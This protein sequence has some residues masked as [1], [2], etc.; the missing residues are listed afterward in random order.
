M[1]DK[2]L[3]V[4][5][6]WVG[7]LQEHH[8]GFCRIMT[9]SRTSV[10]KTQSTV[11][12]SKSIHVQGFLFLRFMDD[13]EV[14]KKSPVD[15]HSHCCVTCRSLS[16]MLPRDAPLPLLTVGPKSL[17]WSGASEK[18][19]KTWLQMGL[20]DASVWGH[21]KDGSP[22]KRNPISAAENELVQLCN[23][24]WLFNWD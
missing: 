21:Y 7:Q 18:R 17:D 15:I 5:L 12:T 14:K 11:S 4:R 13:A 8:S 22:G 1:P 2:G 9:N 16:E 24:S 6:P 19:R 20:M 3:L 23:G 10:C